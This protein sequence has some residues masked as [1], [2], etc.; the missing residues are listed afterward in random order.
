MSGPALLSL[1]PQTHLKLKRSEVSRTLATRF[2]SESSR[3]IKRT[4]CSRTHKGPS[5]GKFW[6]LTSAHTVSP[7]RVFTTHINTHRPWFGRHRLF[8]W[9]LFAESELTHASFL[10]VFDSFISSDPGLAVFSRIPSGRHRLDQI[11]DCWGPFT[12]NLSLLFQLTRP[13][14]HRGSS[15][16]A[17]WSRKK[18]LTDTLSVGSL[19]WMRL[20]QLC[21]T[22]MATS[23]W[24]ILS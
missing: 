2:L 21:D 13:D 22:G 6:P 5:L 8:F 14:T 23:F 3:R 20:R 12:G 16:C 11:G 4:L 24:R 17:N 15:T 19:T 18:G 10:F 7:C 9:L 1:A